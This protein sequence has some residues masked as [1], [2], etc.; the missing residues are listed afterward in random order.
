[1]KI[2]NIGIGLLF[3]AFLVVIIM[4]SGCIGG[5]EKKPQTGE[6][7][8][9]EKPSAENPPVTEE[10]KEEKPIGKSLSDLLGLGKPQGYTVSYDMTGK[11]SGGA[12]KMTMYF[13]G[14]KKMRMDSIRN[15]EGETSEGSIFIKG[16]DL[17]SCTKT[18][19]EWTCL[20][21]TSEKSEENQ[22]EGISNSFEKDPE[23]PLYDGTQN[24]AGVAA[25]C[26]K[27]ESGGAKYRYCIHPQKYLMLLTETYLGGTLEY[28]MIATEVDLGMPQESVFDLP[29]EPKDI[30][31]MMGGSDPCA[32]CEMLSG[33]EKQGC[34]DSCKTP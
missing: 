17:Y 9:A 20:K 13:A 1:M 11:E 28:R 5:E 8:P 29:A 23:K 25:E 33:E 16:D 21:F 6:E 19:G 7:Q 34:L 2:K 27:I 24:I 18:E 22:W 12:S 14:E 31:S 32:I 15:Y 3:A 26:Y 30:G 10:P 4:V